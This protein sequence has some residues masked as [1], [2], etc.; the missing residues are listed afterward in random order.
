MYPVPWHETH[1][2]FIHESACALTR[3]G[4]EVEVIRAV[5]WRPPLGG[6]RVRHVPEVRLIDGISV[7]YT[8]V[9]HPPWAA[10]SCLQAPLR[11][12][13]LRRAIRRVQAAKGFGL[14]HAHE[15]VPTGSATLASARG[16]GVP[17]VCT[18]HGWDL[19]YAARRPTCHGQAARVIREADRL[20]AVS[21]HMAER[22]AR[23]AVPVHDV[24]VVPNGVDLGLFQPAPR[25]H[26]VQELGLGDA[27]IVLYVG[28]LLAQK[29]VLDLLQAFALLAAAHQEVQ[30]VYVGAG[31]LAADIAAR[32]VRAGLSE[33]V[34]VV[35]PR[36][37]AEIPL[38]I[39]SS[40]VCALPS[41]SESFGIVALE[42]MAC[43]RPVVAS[44]VGGLPELVRDGET[45]RL[46]P[47][48]SPSIL[49][50]ALGDL[51]S[52]PDGAMRLASA[53]RAWVLDARLS[54][55]DH[56][57]RLLAVYRAVSAA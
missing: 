27:P 56:A 14:V 10:L 15:V 7:H 24:A 22:A 44:A 12:P 39:A 33:R 42:A 3:A 41:H 53:A 8:I 55:D 11:R 36:P 45:G 32:A 13:G 51:L 18:A 47:A 5:A 21:S 52:D 17:F 48:H 43:A 34:H 26:A 6:G 28:N 19:N 35:G 57:Q 25:A 1:G 38:W 50:A 16:L 29:G 49:S 46:V 20:V 54:W 31:P 30:L 37:R 40:T 2:S 23:V 4:V 9:P